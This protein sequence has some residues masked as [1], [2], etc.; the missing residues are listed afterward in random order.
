MFCPIMVND[1]V[2][3]AASGSVEIVAF[4]TANAVIPLISR[5]MIEPLVKVAC[6][7]AELNVGLGKGVG[8]GV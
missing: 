4:V 6:R 3:W 5:S 8:D 1:K 2:V 7:I